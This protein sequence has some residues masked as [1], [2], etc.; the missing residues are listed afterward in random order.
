MR[1]EQKKLKEDMESLADT[2]AEHLRLARRRR[3]STTSEEDL[4][5]RV[6]RDTT[7][8][9]QQHSL[10]QHDD[11]EMKGAMSAIS[12]RMDGLE[13]ALRD[14]SL[15]EVVGQLKTSRDR[16]DSMASDIQ[17]LQRVQKG[18]S[19]MV[20]HLYYQHSRCALHARPSLTG[21]VLLHPTGAGTAAVAEADVAAGP[22]RNLC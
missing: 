16:I 15:V 6:G 20:R 18:D 7:G 1:R 19:S 8:R 10:Q 2:T 11:S 13:T 21:L 14:F 5:G 9:K 12:G 17:L 4:Q 22:E 3:S